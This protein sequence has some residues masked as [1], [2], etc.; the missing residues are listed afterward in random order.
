MSEF[1]CDQCTKGNENSSG[2]C[3]QCIY[4]DAIDAG[5]VS[6]CRAC[7]KEIVWMKTF[8]GKNIPVNAETFHGELL[9]KFGENIAHFTTCPKADQFRKG[10][11]E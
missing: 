3:A 2:G 11:S 4:R 6:K 8:K 7:D 10:K 9:F 1:T 5:K